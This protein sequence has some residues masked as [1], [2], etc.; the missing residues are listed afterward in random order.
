VRVVR[1]EMPGLT[2]VTR[3]ALS[4]V[5]C[6]TMCGTCAAS[7]RPPAVMLSTAER[8]VEAHRQGPWTPAVHLEQSPPAAHLP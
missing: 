4:E 7:G 1:A 8:L 2:I 5:F 3:D 6:L